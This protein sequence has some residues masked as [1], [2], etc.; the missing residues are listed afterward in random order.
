ML[1]T[2][3]PETEGKNKKKKKKKKKRAGIIQR[4]CSQATDSTGTS[5][6]ATAKFEFFF[7]LFFLGWKKRLFFFFW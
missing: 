4:N 3:L 6:K 5:Q 7:A 2:P 1:H